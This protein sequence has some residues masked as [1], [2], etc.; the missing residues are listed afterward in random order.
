MVLG[1]VQKDTPCPMMAFMLCTG[2]KYC[3]NSNLL[4]H[5][6]VSPTI[7]VW[8][9]LVIHLSPNLQPSLFGEDHWKGS[10]TTVPTTSRYCWLPGLLSV[11]PLP[12]KQHNDIKQRFEVRCHKNTYDTQ[13]HV[14]FLIWLM[15][16][17]LGL[18]P[19]PGCSWELDASC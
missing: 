12:Q 9:W 17:T 15:S 2:I 18:F 10:Y 19:V 6:Y 7:I 1:V 3:P 11:R 14:F 16:H 13:F 8:Y 4:F 5:I